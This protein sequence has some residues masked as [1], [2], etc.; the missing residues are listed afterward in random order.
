[1]PGCSKICFALAVSAP[2]PPVRYSTGSLFVG[3]SLFKIV[4]YNLMVLSFDLLR[5]SG[6]TRKPHCV[7]DPGFSCCWH[8][9]GSKRGTPLCIVGTGCGG[10][11]VVRLKFSSSQEARNMA[12]ARRKK[13]T[14]TAVL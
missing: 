7:V 5:F 4:M 10:V 13:G 2:G 14:Y 11:V 6:T 9:V 12:R 3:I 1:M 8:A